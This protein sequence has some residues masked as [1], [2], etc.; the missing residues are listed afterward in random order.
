LL[1]RETELARLAD[2]VAAV[3][4][5]ESRS[6]V[7]RGEPGIGKT[8]LLEYLV[9]Q[10]SD[11]A[12]FR[13]A[14][15]ESEMELPFATLHQL[16]APMLDALE[17]LPTPQR[18][19]LEVVFGLS[20]GAPPDR[21]LVG[22]ALLSLFAEAAERRPL[23]CVV[24]DAQ[25]LDRAS[26]VTLAFVA[27][28]LLAEPVGI[29]FGAREPGPELS[30]LPELQLRGLRN[31]DARELLKSAVHFALDARIRDRIIAET[32]GNPLALLELPRGLTATEL[33]DGFPLSGPLASGI[34]ESFLRQLNPLSEDARRLL[35]LAAAEPVGDPLLL[36]R[37]SEKLGLGSASLAAAQDS[38]LLYVGG[39][40]TFRHPLVRSAVYQ[41]ASAEE[42]RE[43]HGVLAE[44]TDPEL[45][46]DRRAWHLAAACV[47]PDEQV[48]RELERSAERARA[49]G[50]LAAAAAFLD[51]SVAL[52]ADPLRR[53]ERALA[54]AEASLNAGAFDSALRLLAIAEGTQLDDLQR[55]RLALLQAYTAHALRRGSDAPPLLLQAAKTLEPLDSKL[56]R[57][58]YLDAW[59][60]ALFAGQLAS[61]G[62]L[63]D[64]SRAARAAPAAPKPASPPDLLLDGLALLMTEG[65]A[66][67]APLLQQAA[68]G[69]AGERAAAQDVLRWG[70]LA[71][72]GSVVVWD[73]DSC[74]TIASRGVELA[75]DSGAL[76]VLSV[77][78]N[79]MAQAVAM[80]GEFA[81]AAQLISEAAIVTEATGTPVLSYGAL[82]LHAFQGHEEEVL[83][84]SERTIR[85][86]TAAGQG[87]ALE[88]AYLARAV[89]LN[90]QGRHR[91]ALAPARETSDFT[92]E[93]VVAGWGLIELAEAAA[94]CGEMELAQSAL[95]RIAERNGWIATDWGLGIEAR[96]RAL[97]SEGEA[98]DGLY[99]DAIERLGRTRL[100]P[101]LARAHLLHG[102][103][104]RREGR[105]REA[106]E[107]LRTA[108][109]M[110]AGLGM[111]AFAER[112]SS[113]LLATGENAR[114]RPI[115]MHDDLTAQER[116]IAGLARD[117]L[118]N[119]EIAAR[120]FLSRRTVEWHLRKVFGKLEI[121]S[122][123][124]L[125]DALDQPQA[126]SIET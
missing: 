88:Y 125:S 96:A 63:Y 80:G 71:T 20:A 105:R 111:T 16:C 79:I 43:V 26:A 35:L 15:V 85:E 61:D 45:D 60:A 83:E 77:A 62:S 28:R 87:T 9:D 104:L 11:L 14:G 122:R 93:L 114:R 95:E 110:L 19:A 54:A 119:P 33:A 86:A 57:E 103:W 27:R 101:E 113:E 4:R 94:R 56:A 115:E 48:A 66:A 120:L 52:S 38:E 3:R 37:A 39:W 2:L 25:W 53:T 41:E 81:R 84:L 112:A 34:E 51:R 97:L 100:R 7:V 30:R 17:S 73:Y 126:S 72:V 89:V 74:L 102:E 90:G 1:G 106:R 78:L 10:A 75:R 123:Y 18:Q 67:G 55:G 5:A 8:L 24:D 50:G 58:T 91:E 116:Q 6:L 47:G 22:L 92:P 46:P 12:V 82:Y 68:I 44:V 124:E 31:G 70:W 98:A 23:L 108:H 40:V 117:G 76:T 59:S 21:F 13:A 121:H 69:F 65:R 99:R 29:V 49:R 109:D 32:R 107:R 42:R 118:S 36:S 64:V